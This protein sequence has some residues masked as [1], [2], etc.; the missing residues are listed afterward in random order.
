[1]VKREVTNIDAGTKETVL[2]PV[3]EMVVEYRLDEI[4]A[5]GN[6]KEV[7]LYGWRFYEVWS[8]SSFE[9][10]ARAG[11]E[12]MADWMRIEHGHLHGRL[13]KVAIHLY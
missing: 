9:R 11:L 10:S 4:L 13:L 2:K 12:D 6:L 8:L 3:E 7:C 1:L 5:C